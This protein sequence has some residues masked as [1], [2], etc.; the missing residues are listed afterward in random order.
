MTWRRGDGGSVYR[1]YG[2]GY[3]NFCSLPNY[4]YACVSCV[5]VPPPM[6]F[7]FGRA[8]SSSRRVEFRIRRLS[9]FSHRAG[10]GA[11]Q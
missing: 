9:F 3:L 10:V 8:R 2:P 6:T 1:D 4:A 11:V 7:L 5:C